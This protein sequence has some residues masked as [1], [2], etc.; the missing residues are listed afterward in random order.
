MERILGI[1]G[2]RRYKRYTRPYGYAWSVNEEFPFKLVR[3]EPQAETHDKGIHRNEP[4]DVTPKRFADK[5]A[6]LE[7]GRTVPFIFFRPPFGY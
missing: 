2:D 5:T 1:I 7:G 3:A 4:N 6:Y